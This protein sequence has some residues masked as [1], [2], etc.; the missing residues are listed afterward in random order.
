MANYHLE[1]YFF[2]TKDIINKIVR[3]LWN[4]YWYFRFHF[5]KYIY[6]RK[7]N[8]KILYRLFNIKYAN[9]Y[10][11]FLRYLLR[12]NFPISQGKIYVKSIYYF[13][14]QIRIQI[15]HYIIKFDTTNTVFTLEY[16]FLWKRFVLEYISVSVL[17]IGN[18]WY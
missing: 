7:K 9:A 13:H 4:F 17:C 6:Y 3:N 5:Y 11:L 8:H 15:R 1:I 12:R 2:H 10:F 14:K 16:Q 18:T